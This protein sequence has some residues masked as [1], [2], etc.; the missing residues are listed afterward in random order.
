MMRREILLDTF[1]GGDY[2]ATAKARLRFKGEDGVIRGG[3]SLEAHISDELREIIR[4]L[5]EAEIARAVGDDV[6]TASKGTV[7]R[8]DDDSIPV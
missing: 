3:M 1:E 7:A 8:D 5:V 4:S 6:E 2:S